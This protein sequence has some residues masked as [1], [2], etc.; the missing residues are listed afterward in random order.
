MTSFPAAFAPLESV[1]VA[2]VREDGSLVQAN[3][4]FRRL[5][6]DAGPV[7]D[8]DLVQRHFL[9]PT[10]RAL[11]ARVADA[12][13]TV[14]RG[15][16]TLGDYEGRSWSLRASIRRDAAGLHLLAEHDIGELE[17]VSQSIRSLNED[18]AT[19]QFALA[20]ANLDL[21]GL[22]AALEHER[23]ELRDT[24]DRLRRLEG[25]LSICSYCS[26]VRTEDD[27]W[28]KVEHYVSEHSDVRFSHGVCPT[29]FAAEMAALGAAPSPAG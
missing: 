22:N 13:G 12:D 28:Q 2:T 1:A 10:F 21:Q 19:M 27:S 18:Y 11:C 5:V 15:L 23:T 17:R 4:G 16:I 29:C 6:E 26:K 14:H 8:G 7:A 24:L 20:R 3:A 9:Q 25:L